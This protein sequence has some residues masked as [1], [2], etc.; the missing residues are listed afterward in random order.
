MAGGAVLI[1][2]CDA[3]RSVRAGGMIDQRRV[4]TIVVA[5]KVGQTVST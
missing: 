5:A 1:Y 4:G 3:R 2:S